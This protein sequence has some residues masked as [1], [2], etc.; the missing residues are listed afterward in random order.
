MATGK[1]MIGYLYPY[2][3]VVMGISFFR[4]LLEVQIG[5]HVTKNTN[6]CSQYSCICLIIPT[7]LEFQ[8]SSQKDFFPRHGDHFLF[9][10]LSIRIFNGNPT[11][12]I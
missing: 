8:Y 9:L 10:G 7:T 3:D 4:G 11:G 1:R 5:V 12:A 2:G 6:L